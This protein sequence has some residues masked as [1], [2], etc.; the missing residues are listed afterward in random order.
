MSILNKY[1]TIIIGAGFSGLLSALALSREGKNVLVIEKDDIIGGVCRSYSV[2]GYTVD[3][4]P[5]IITR[6]DS[7]PL[8]S[9]MDKYFDVIPN[10][11]S[12]G[13]YYVRLGDRIK[14][15]PW[16]VKEWMLF[17]LLP[18]EDRALLMKTVFDIVY[19]ISLGK[20]F[21]NISLDDM[22]PKNVSNETAFF[23]DYLSYF[24]LGTSPC[25]APISRFIDRKEYK[26]DKFEKG[27]FGALSY[28]GRLHNLLIGGRPSDQ[29][30]PRGGIKNII[31]SILFS[32]PK[33]VKIQLNER[34]VT[35]NVKTSR[36]N[37]QNNRIVQGISTDKEEY[38]CD[39]L[40]YSG[41]S[42]ELP[43]LV[44]CEL[45]EDYV[46][47]VN[48]IKQVDSLTI[49]LGLDKQFFV[50][51]GS[52]MW[53]ASEEEKLHT[54]LVPTSN[55]DPFL[56]PKNK[57][58]VGFAFIKPDNLNSQEM[59]KRA[60]DTIFGTMPELENH[61]DMMH[62]QE[63]IPEKACWSINSGFG[64][65]MTPLSNLYC[66]GSDAEKRSMGLT[67]SSYSVLRMIESLNLG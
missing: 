38:V 55:Y 67:R 66:V 62:V 33:N 16:S 19:S 29:V 20:D 54:W 53:V 14:P 61:V 31:E 40:I 17:D 32:L 56:A 42:T 10:F 1:D 51:Q 22:V 12:L 26:Q 15:F 39:T 13:D 36:I 50:K 47:N 28:V 63:L 4:G 11:V 59:R 41:F 27:T 64:D 49:W 37:G 18:M 25:N 52:E 24:M 8:K 5:H 45:P 46:T 6:M 58:L 23:I 65:V 35:I 7:G 2:D 43:E 48:S 3:T 21:S 44:Q 30:Y 60:R 9:L 57:H 34:L